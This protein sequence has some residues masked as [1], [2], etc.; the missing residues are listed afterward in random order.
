MT[1]HSGMTGQ[2]SSATVTSARVTTELNEKCAHA[3]R[4]YKKEV[5]ASQSK[6]LKCFHEER[7][8]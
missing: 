3:Y 2:S 4:V 1:G 7:N 6:V 8:E 5:Q